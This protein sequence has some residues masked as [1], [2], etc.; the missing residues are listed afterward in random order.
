MF[1]KKIN[2]TEIF[3][4]YYSNVIGFVCRVL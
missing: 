1:R 4:R 3:W 2:A